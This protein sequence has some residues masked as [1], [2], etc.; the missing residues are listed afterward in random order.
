MRENRV[1]SGASRRGHDCRGR[2]GRGNVRGFK[3][4]EVKADCWRRGRQQPLR[5][6]VHVY[7]GVPFFWWI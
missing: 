7:S 2:G 3:G 6:R 1:E 5:L 4:G